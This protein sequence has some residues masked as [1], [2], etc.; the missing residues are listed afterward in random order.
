VSLVDD[1]TEH[2]VLA[3]R[4]DVRSELG[5]EF[6]ELDGVHPSSLAWSV[7]VALALGVGLLVSWPSLMGA[8]GG[9]VPLRDA[10]VQL[11][12]TATVALLG[13]TFVAALYRFLV[14][15]SAGSDE[16]VVVAEAVPVG[17]SGSGESDV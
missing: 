4:E 2:D 15:R 17:G 6:D 5:D 9:S 11:A 7:H 10:L 8:L 16:S 13:I 1:L 3:S 14:D 12:A